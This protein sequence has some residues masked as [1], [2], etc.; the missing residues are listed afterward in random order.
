MAA[1]APPKLADV[2]RDINRD[3]LATLDRPGKAY[4]A[5]LA[6][7]MSLVGLGAFAFTWQT[8]WG[9]GV[10]GYAPPVMW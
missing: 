9:L 7:V 2:F 3:I 10:A 8:Y 4:Y 1:I 6:F 5:L